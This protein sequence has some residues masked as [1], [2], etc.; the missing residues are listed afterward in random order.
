MKS[1][2]MQSVKYWMGYG[3]KILHLLLCEEIEVFSRFLGLD[4]DCHRVRE[5]R[6]T[7][8][9]RTNYVYES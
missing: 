6:D 5:K 7:V 8:G 2:V 3:G 4:F 1:K 9:T